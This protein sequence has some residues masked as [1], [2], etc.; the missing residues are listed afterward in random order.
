MSLEELEKK[1]YGL[2]RKDDAE[3]RELPKKEQYENEPVVQTSWEKEAE[4]VA[5]EEKGKGMGTGIK[6]AFWGGIIALLAVGGAAYYYISEYYK[7][8]DL[9]FDAQTVEKVLIGRPFDVTV[10]VENKSQAILRQGKILVRLPDGVVQIGNDT[11]KQTIEEE[12]GDVAA[13]ESI[14]KKYTL[15]IVKD[16]QST[17]KVETNFSYLPQNINTRFERDKTLEVNVDQSAITLNF[18]TPQKVFSTENFD[19]S[20]Q[21]HNISDMEF[22]DAKIKLVTAKGFVY[23]DASIKPELGNDSWNIASLPPEAENTIAV[24][25]SLEGV[26]QESF[27]IKAQVVEMLNGKEYV[28]NEKVANLGIASSPLSLEILANNNPQYIAKPGETVSYV[29]HYKNN[30]EVGLNDAVIKATVKGEMFDITSLRTKGSFDSI[31]NTLTWTAASNPELKLLNPGAE[32]TVD[33][34]IP[35][36]TGYPISRMFDKN[37]TVKVGAEIDSPTVPYNVASDRTVGFANSEVKISGDIS[38]SDAADR[39]KVLPALQAN[40]PTKYTVTWTIRNYSTDM[41][42]VRVV[43]GLQPGVKWLGGIKSNSGTD[44]VYNDRTGEL[45]WKIDKIIATKGAIGIPTQVT[46]Q[47]EVTPNVTQVG[48]VLDLTK[49][50]T[51]TATDGF[52]G[53]AVSRS[54]KGLQTGEPVVR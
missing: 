23:K 20:I 2:D 41:T 49:D 47:I 16:E 37:F 24:K 42:G 10:D 43:S 19:M 40:K 1:L 35:I 6:V 5:Q 54:L 25:G 44:P 3:R 26:G 28:I 27:E 18:T 53:E 45:E 39:V 30:T 34:T 8:K 46:F 29:L 31:T 51:L 12:V 22:K 15:V 9:V 11:E 14:E 17:K 50:V 21:Y 48:A 38:I 13:G 52:T 33:F 4:P 32:G 36:K 7:T